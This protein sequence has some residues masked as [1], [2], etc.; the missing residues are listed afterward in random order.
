MIN[1]LISLF[2]ILSPQNR[3]IYLIG[4]S[5]IYGDMGEELENLLSYK[6]NVTTMAV[7]GA[8]SATYAR[9]FLINTCCAYQFRRVVGRRRTVLL[10]GDKKGEKI[11]NIYNSIKTS[12]PELIIIHLGNNQGDN[13]DLLLYNI[14]KVTKAKIIWVGVFK[15]KSYKKI[16]SRIKKSIAKFQNIE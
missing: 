3:E 2:F 12:S 8:G 11:I 15:L 14:R 7:V 4:D 1:I 10:E 6:A 13:H 16:N 5:H 9:P